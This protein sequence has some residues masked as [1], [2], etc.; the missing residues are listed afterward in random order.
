MVGTAGFMHDARETILRRISTC[1]GD[2]RVHC[3]IQVVTSRYMGYA[4]TI[5]RV[6]GR[7][8]IESYRTEMGL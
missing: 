2:I 5:E 6:V 3:A 4:V 1:A 8:A 7:D